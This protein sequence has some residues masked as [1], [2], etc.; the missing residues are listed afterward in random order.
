MSELSTLEVIRADEYLHN[1]PGKLAVVR[2]ATDLAPTVEGRRPDCINTLAAP[3][4]QQLVECSYQSHIVDSVNDAER[5]FGTEEMVEERLADPTAEYYFLVEGQRL[6][7]PIWY[8]RKEPPLEGGRAMKDAP[9]TFAVRLFEGFLGRHLAAPFMEAT[10]TDFK[11]RHDEVKKVWL[12][13]DYDNVLAKNLYAR[14][15]WERTMVDDDKREYW[16]RCLTRTPR[17]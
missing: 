17:R 7:G 3:L 6:G 16:T 10:L 13:T 4:V 15:G 9:Y 1:P 11:M 12:S 5:R 2:A 14:T 8:R